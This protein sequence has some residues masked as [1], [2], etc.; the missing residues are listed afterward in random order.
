MS[1]VITPGIRIDGRGIAWVEGSTA[2]VKELIGIGKQCGLS[3][4]GIREQLPHLSEGQIE[5]ALA[6]F[7]AHREEVEA[8]LE[9]DERW[10]EEARAAEHEPLSRVILESRLRG[11]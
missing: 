7:E 3:V 11:R 6:F 4:K 5:A 10:Y 1:T 8:Q 2:K 9:A